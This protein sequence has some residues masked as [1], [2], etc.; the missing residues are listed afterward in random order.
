MSRKYFGGYVHIYGI[1]VNA[2]AIYRHEY[3]RVQNSQLNK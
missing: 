1:L 2:G 3:R